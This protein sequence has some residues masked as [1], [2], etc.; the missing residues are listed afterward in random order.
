MKPKKDGKRSV[1]YAKLL[2]PLCK[3]C[4]EE[5]NQHER[6]HTDDERSFIGT[7]TMD[8]VNLSIS[9]GYR[10]IKVYEVWHFDEKVT[11]YLD[12]M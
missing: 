6:E 12:V 3:K 10:V 9:K 11:I 1:T 7:W 8:E 5:A 4:A 2:F